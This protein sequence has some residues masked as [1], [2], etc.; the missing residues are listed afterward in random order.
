[1]MRFIFVAL[2]FALMSCGQK[3]KMVLNGMIGRKIHFPETMIDVNSQQVCESGVKVLSFVDS[4]L[5]T[6]CYLKTLKFWDIILPEIDSLNCSVLFVFS[7]V[8][9]NLEE[10]ISMIREECKFL[11]KIDVDNEFILKNKFIRGHGVEYSTVLLD[12]EN[13]IKLV[14]NPVYNTRIWSLYKNTIPA[15]IQSEIKANE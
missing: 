5:C 1:M 13:Q 15:M 10:F 2:L 7:P 12:A 6:E 14:G 11:A 9:E 8:D 4:N 3:E